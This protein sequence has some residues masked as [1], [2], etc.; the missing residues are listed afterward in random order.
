M[1]KPYE[2]R[3]EFIAWVA[4]SILVPFF[5]PLAGVPEGTIDSRCVLLS[6]LMLVSA[7]Q[8]NLGNDRDGNIHTVIER[9][10]LNSDL[11]EDNYFYLGYIL[12]H[13]TER[14]CP[15]YLQPEFFSKLKRSIHDGKLILFHGTLAD[16][17]REDAV[18]DKPPSYTAAIMLDHLDWMDDAGACGHACMLSCF[19]TDCVVCCHQASTRSCLCSGRC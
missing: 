13:Y 17:L 14:C 18:N 15:R 8:L 10:F 2:G 9:V 1:V 3:L 5:A 11:V 12:G 7:A 4:D 16:R 19:C 6:T